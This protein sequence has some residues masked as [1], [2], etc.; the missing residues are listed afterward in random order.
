[1]PDLRNN[2][3]VQFAVLVIAVTAGQV[4]LKMLVAQIPTDAGVFGAIKSVVGKV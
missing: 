1:M 2:V 4:L 3:L